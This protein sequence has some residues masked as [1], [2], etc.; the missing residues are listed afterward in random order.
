MVLLMI[1]MKFIDI[2]YSVPG[3]SWNKNDLMSSKIRDE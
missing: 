1:V 3:K 2:Y